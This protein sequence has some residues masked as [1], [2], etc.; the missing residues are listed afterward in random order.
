MWISTADRDLIG[1]AR[2]TSAY[3]QDHIIAHELAHLICGHAGIVDAQG[4]AAELLFPDL[5]PGLLRRLLHR[6]SC[7]DGQ[8]EEAEIMA[9]ILVATVRGRP[10]SST[11]DSLDGIEA[12]L[13]FRRS[14]DR[15]YG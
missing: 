12:A 7:T 15:P 2:N 10:G 5:H 11:S 4:S 9:G 8:E 14:A 1:Y 6:A 3:H 13:G